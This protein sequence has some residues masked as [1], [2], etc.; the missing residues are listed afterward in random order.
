MRF[1]RLAEHQIRKAEAE[2]R[3]KNLKGAGKPLPRDATSGS[4]DAVGFRIMSENGAVPE[5]ITL[6]KAVEQQR[7]VLQQT[8]DP[9]QH[10]REMR[11]LS[12]MQLR[13]AIQEEARRR[14][15]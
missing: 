8:T 13:L 15:Y 5:E 1:D 14:F 6:R 2:G 12:D 7:A 9:E 11:K 4:A 3:L 10:R